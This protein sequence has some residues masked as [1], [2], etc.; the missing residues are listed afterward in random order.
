MDLL[1]DLSINAEIEDLVAQDQESDV[2]NLNEPTIETITKDNSK[3]DV[4]SVDNMFVK[5]NNDVVVKEVDLETPE[6][7]ITKKG[8]IKKPAT[9]KQ[10]AHLAKIRAKALETRR[11]NSELKKQAVLETTKKIKENKRKNTKKV[12]ITPPTET[13]LI[14]QTPPPHLSTENKI[15]E[16]ESNE[17][18]KFLGNMNKFMMLQEKHE[19][20]QRKIAAIREKQNR[21]KLERENKKRNI[22]VSKPKQIPQKEIVNR[23]FIPGINAPMKVEKNPYDDYFG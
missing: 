10:K 5:P 21:E 13:Q 11:K 22:Q 1:P 14:Q 15:T 17:F 19:A 18:Q 3:I 7:Q 4:E 12:I 9:E 16:M 20:E 8:R 6:P 2:D 23:Q